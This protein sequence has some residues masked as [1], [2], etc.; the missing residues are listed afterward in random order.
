MIKKVLLIAAALILAISCS[1]NNPTTPT[2]NGDTGIG[3]TGGGSI[4]EEGTG[5]SSPTTIADFLKKHEGR[6]YD[7]Y[8]YQSGNI[9]I[10]ERDIRLRIENGKIYNGN[11]K[12]ENDMSQAKIILSGNKLQLEFI[13]ND[14]LKENSGITLFN[15]T[16]N[17]I[18]VYAKQILKKENFQIPN[19]Y[20]E[21]GTLNGAAAYTGS[22]YQWYQASSSSPMVKSYIF[23]IDENGKIYAKQSMKDW[24]YELNGN[25]LSY[26]ITEEN[27]TLK[28]TFIMEQDRAINDVIYQ[29]DEEV[30]MEYKKSDLLTPYVGIYSGENIT[31]TVDEADAIMTPTLNN[32]TSILNGNVLTIYELSSTMKEH[33]IVFNAD[34]TATYTKPDNGGTVILKKN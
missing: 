25:I 15:F 24:K 18:Q 27:I 8:E 29:N 12:T 11:E 32:Y 23:T 3:N 19:G 2:N 7:E 26:Y 14:S 20:I 16:D 33:K 4:I 22:Y 1:K 31:L 5:T 21:V 13:G 6:Y 10:I 34:G 9:N 30:F 17:T 28:Y